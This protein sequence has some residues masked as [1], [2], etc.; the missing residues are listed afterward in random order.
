M[1]QG[2]VSQPMGQ[3]M[4]GNMQSQSL[5]GMPN[6]MMNVGPQMSAQ[7]RPGQPPQ[8]QQQLMMMRVS[9]T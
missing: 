8:Q 4:M 9:I 7:Q 6:Q 1:P 2:M 3:Q 5:P